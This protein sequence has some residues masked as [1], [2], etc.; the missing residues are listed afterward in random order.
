MMGCAP[1]LSHPT[2]GY[3][4]QNKNDIVIAR[5]SEGIDYLVE[6]NS[7]NYYVID[8]GTLQMFDP[9]TLPP[10]LVRCNESKC[11]MTGTLW[12]TPEVGATVENDEKSLYLNNAVQYA[13]R[14]DFTTATFGYLFF[15]LD[16]MTEK[17]AQIDVTIADID[18]YDFENSYTYRILKNKEKMYPGFEVMQVA[19]GDHT[20]I[21][22]QTGNGW[23][24]SDRGIR[25]KIDVK[26]TRPI[27]TDPDKRN[28][29]NSYAGTT[30]GLSSLKVICDKSELHK[31]DNVILSCLQS[32]QPDISVDATDAS[33]FGQ[34]YDKDS[35]SV[36]FSIEARTRSKNDF[37]I[38]PFERKGDQLIAAIPKT[39]VKTIEEVEIVNGDKKEVYG[40]FRLPDLAEGCNSIIVS[41]GQECEGIYLE[42]LQA[43]SVTPVDET[44]FVAIYRPKEDDFGVVYVNKRHIDKK[45]LVTYD[46]ETEVDHFVADA[47]KLDSFETEFIVPITQ[48]NGIKE[49]VKFYAL[50]T[51]H[52]T[53]FTPTDEASLS[54]TLQVVRKN[55][56]FYD[57]FRLVN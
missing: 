2:Y 5:V 52:S 51:E 42:P 46:A 47:E 38:N 17:F 8:N 56:K 33:C 29:I 26:T 40:R 3:G 13:I 31:S 23:T 54:L 7:K 37:W 45:V 57:R 41:L 49:Y 9:T 30:V 14:G 16:Y 55:G 22:S 53:E 24:P 36:E 20:Q 11:H 28:D 39:V 19:F 4:I 21:T 18:D 1:K 48:N 34:Q 6:Y 35:A 10:D 12:V 44:E 50:V 32:I 25:I 27:A 43:P 15:Y